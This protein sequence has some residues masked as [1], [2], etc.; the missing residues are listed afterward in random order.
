MIA[1]KDQFERIQ[2]YL[3]DRMSGEDRAIFERDLT[4]DG[5]LRRQFEE[6]ALLAHSVKKACQEADLRMALDET[7]RQLAET[8]VTAEDYAAIEVECVRAEEELLRIGAQIDVPVKEAPKERTRII[9]HHRLYSFLK[10]T[11]CAIAACFVA[12]VCMVGILDYQTYIVGKGYDF[13]SF[14]SQIRGRGT[15]NIIQAIDEGSIHDALSLI[16]DYREKINNDLTSC[17]EEDSDMVYELDADLQE[18]DFLEAICYLRKGVYFK[19]KKKLQFIMAADSIYG[20][21]ASRLF[22]ELP[23]CSK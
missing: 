13:I 23:L 2:E 19:A 20:E 7:E 18:L 3:Q 16:D 12:A 17:T 15:D 21:D 22:N 11:S 6:L 9:G 8:S 14:E 4:T 5:V 10:W 1:E